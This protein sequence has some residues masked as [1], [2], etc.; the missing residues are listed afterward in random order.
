MAQ[1]GGLRP[2]SLPCISTRML[3]V[4]W[5]RPPVSSFQPAALSLLLL[6]FEDGD[7]SGDVASSGPDQATRPLDVM[8][9]ASQQSLQELAWRRA[10]GA[11]VGLAFGAVAGEADGFGG[12]PAAL[13]TARAAPSLPHSTRRRTLEDAW[14]PSLRGVSGCGGAVSAAPPHGGITCVGCSLDA[15]GQW[16]RCRPRPPSASAIARTVIPSRRC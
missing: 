4:P 8:G 15:T 2:S 7:C 12:R 3:L 10:S 9:G 13:R 16:L 1:N 14:S 6:S 5:P 11:Q